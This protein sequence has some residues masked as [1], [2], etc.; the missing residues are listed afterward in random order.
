M[1]RG[2]VQDCYNRQHHWGVAEMPKW[3][4]D[5]IVDPSGLTDADWAEI[6]RLKTA[7]ETGGEKALDSAFEQLAADPIRAYRVVA[8]LFPEMLREQTKDALAER[9]ITEEDL[10][11]MLKKAK[12]AE[13]PSSKR[14]LSPCRGCS[15]DQPRTLQST[16]YLLQ[17]IPGSPSHV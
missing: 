11:E 16:A 10:R 1:F 8:A 5:E 9:G 12:K 15:K 2:P 17:P 14:Q 4:F 7:Y 13:G 3:P 6:N